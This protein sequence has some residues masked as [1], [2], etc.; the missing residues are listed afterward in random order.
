MVKGLGK[1]IN[2]NF[3]KQTQD[4]L[5]AEKD[6]HECSLN[7]LRCTVERF[8]KGIDPNILIE[9]IK[10]YLLERDKS[11]I[12]NRYIF[13]NYLQNLQ[14]L[15]F[16]LHALAIIIKIFQLQMTANVREV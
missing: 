6:S 5:T 7:V 11:P 9:D 13:P 12:K 4:K 1:N 14:L 16:R 8:N 2:V 15:I 10:Q 3:T